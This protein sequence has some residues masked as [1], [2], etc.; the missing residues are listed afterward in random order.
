MYSEWK[1]SHCVAEREKESKHLFRSVFCSLNSVRKLDQTPNYKVMTETSLTSSCQTPESA[2]IFC[3]S[4]SQKTICSTDYISGKL[5][6]SSVTTVWKWS[7]LIC[8]CERS[9]CH[10]FIALT[11]WKYSC[12][13]QRPVTGWRRRHVAW[14]ACVWTRRANHRSCI[15][16]SW[17]LLTFL[18]FLFIPRFVMHQIN[19]IWRQ[20]SRC[21]R[22]DGSVK[23]W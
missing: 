9:V 10:Q 11:D 21:G 3:A 1:L 8:L 12:R 16:I 15:F 4:E 7:S 18:G 20:L 14:A 6:L 22:P 17:H 13:T 23:S 2:N 5:P 19:T